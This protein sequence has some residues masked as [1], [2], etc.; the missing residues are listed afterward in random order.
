MRQLHHNCEDV[1]Q[2]RKKHAFL[3][4]FLS[5][6]YPIKLLVCRQRKLEESLLFSGQFKDALQ[7]LL[8]WLCKIEPFIS[9]EQNVHGDIETVIKLTEQ[10]KVK[11]VVLTTHV[12]RAIKC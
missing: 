3:P 5:Y 6:L 10:Q 7:A 2:K 1:I 8:G 4:P 9:D 11:P 12:G